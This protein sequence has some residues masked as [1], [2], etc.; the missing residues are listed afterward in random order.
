M[1][2]VDRREQKNQ[3][4]EQWFNDHGIEYYNFSLPVGDY[5]K[6]NDHSVV[7][8]KK[9]GLQEV[10]GNIVQQHERF[11]NECKLA[12]KAGI[13]LIILVEEEN[14]RDLDD[15]CLWVNPRRTEWENIEKAHREGRMLGVKN[16][17]KPPMNSLA[18]AS[19]M[20]TIS[21]NTGIEWR[22]VNKKNCAEEIL[23]LLGVNT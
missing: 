8:D 11:T 21:K 6:M 7:V 15:V 4:I 12:Q 18:L 19:A 1:I 20:R 23:H 5:A 13:R 17:S 14:I 2:Q 22:F 3:H 16:R 10:Y 9:S